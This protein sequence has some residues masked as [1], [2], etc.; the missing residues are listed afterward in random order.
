MKNKNTL[1]N[2]K[3]GNISITILVLIVFAICSLTLL[4]FYVAEKSSENA[5]RQVRFVSLINFLSE[6]ADFYSSLNLNEGTE[7]V[8]KEGFYTGDQLFS[9]FSDSYTFNFLKNNDGKT[10]I[11]AKYYENS[12]LLWLKKKEVLSITFP[13]QP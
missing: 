4:S 11:S 2:S 6:Q 13:Y 8:F 7:S 3:Q 10:V 1:L 12:G 9:D 5:F